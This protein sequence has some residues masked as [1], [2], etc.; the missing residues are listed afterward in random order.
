MA[1]IERMWKVA[2]AAVL[3]TNGL[4]GKA[5]SKYTPRF[6]AKGDGFNLL[7]PIKSSKSGIL[8]TRL[9]WLIRMM[10]VILDSDYKWRSE[11]GRRHED[12]AAVFRIDVADELELLKHTQWFWL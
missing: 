8:A 5:L 11:N 12:A 10:P 9:G 3:W 6:R 1:T 4:K 2:V 7:M